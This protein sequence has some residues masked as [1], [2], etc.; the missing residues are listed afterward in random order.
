M[1]RRTDMVLDSVRR[2]QRLQKEDSSDQGEKFGPDREGTI[3]G[4]WKLHCGQPS[5]YSSAAVHR[6]TVE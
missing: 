2:L 3:A 5:S 6:H 1:A 4:L